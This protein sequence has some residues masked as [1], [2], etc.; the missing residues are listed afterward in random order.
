[1][2]ISLFLGAGMSAP[3]SMPTTAEFKDIM[4]RKYGQRRAW[5][6]LLAD[7]ALPDIEHVWAAVESFR[8]LSA[9]P[10]GEY[11]ADDICS[12]RGMERHEVAEL[13]AALEDEVFDAYRWDPR[14]DPLL[15]SVLAPVLALGAGQDGARQVFTTNYD[16]SVEECCAA[17][18]QGV[19]FYDGFEY[20]PQR[21]RVL[22]SGF[23]GRSSGPDT[24]NLYKM[25]GSL[26]WKTSRHGLERTTHEAKAADPNY[27]DFVI[28]PT[29]A[30]KSPYE[31][32]YGEI[33][34]GFKE[35]LRSSD[36]CVALGYSFRDGAIARQFGRLVEDGNTLVAVGPDAISNLEN[37]LRH[38]SLAR[39]REEWEQVCASHFVHRSGHA[40]IHAVQEEIRPETV[41]DTV[42]HV[43]RIISPQLRAPAGAAGRAERGRSAAGAPHHSFSASRN[44]RGKLIRVQRYSHDKIDCCLS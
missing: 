8:N 35:G 33:F 22:W 23:A 11:W 3:Y 21:G 34:D 40:S 10:G 12:N 37:V 2:K 25:H 9:S 6:R 4:F 42:R 24:L 43:Q 13:Q 16:R 7:A 38:T 30:P 32:V 1:M 19:R 39:G 44:R 41:H 31:G 15:S 27:R 5:R 36:A 28:Y 14:N 29:I 20:D 18:L 17:T 26:G